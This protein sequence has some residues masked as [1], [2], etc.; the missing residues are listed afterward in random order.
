VAPVNQASIVL[1]KIVLERP[2]EKT[3]FAKH[4]LNSHCI[5]RLHFVLDIHLQ[6]SHVD[7]LREGWALGFWPGDK[8]RCIC[9]QEQPKQSGNLTCDS[10]LTHLIGF[11]FPSRRSPRYVFRKNCA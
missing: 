4:R 9:A 11:T 2:V 5:F 7:I 8:K 6:W 10:A 1:E 3:D